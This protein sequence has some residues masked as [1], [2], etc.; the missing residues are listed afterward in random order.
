MMF[1]YSSIWLCIISFAYAS[2]Q[3]VTVQLQSGTVVTG[4]SSLGVD[5]F[6]GIP[7]ADPPVGQRRLRPP[8][9]LSRKLSSVDAR[10]IAAAC[11]QQLLSP[12]DR[13]ALGK[14][15]SQVLNLPILQELKGQEDCLSVSVQR[16]S[17]TKP[18]DK[19]P[20]VVWIYGGGF[21]LGSTNTYDATSLLRDAV[22]QHQPFVFVAINYR[23][24][25]F[26]FMPGADIKQEGSANAGLLDQRMGL[27]WV[28]DNVAQFGGDPDKVT[29]WGESAGSM[30]V[31]FQMAVFGGNATYNGKPL[32]RGGIMNSGTTSPADVIDGVKGQA[33][34]DQVVKEAGCSGI[35]KNETL[36]CLRNLDY[37]AF[38]KAVTETFPGIFSFFGN[39]NTFLPRADGHVLP[40]S[41][42]ELAATGQYH[43]VPLIVGDQEDEGTIFSIFQTSIK[44][45]DDFVNYL[46]ENMFANATKDQLS[47]L[48]E[49]YTKANE[50][51][52]FRSSPINSLYPM[53]RTIAAVLGDVTFTLSRRIF[54]ETATKIYPNVPIWSY[55]SSYAH[56]LPIL[57]TFHGSDLLQVFNGLP[58]SHATSST[59]QYY[60]NFFYNQDPNKGN[61]VDANWPL[62][63]ENKTL[64]W[65][66][67]LF[68]ND[69]LTDSFRGDQFAVLAKL[70][71]AKVLRQ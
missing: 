5:S 1:P 56:P 32:F 6:N 40:L 58:P 24:G 65:F 2:A 21:T 71:E 55:L 48:V 51:S 18:G 37:D 53:F 31:F 38:Y 29:L 27:E 35:E 45:D 57:G 44:T 43:A 49:V 4:R 15:G 19:L 60:F 61:V 70:A 11:P 54:I 23:L 46:S 28:A 52:P 25:A 36:S 68:S 7:Y 59:R 33:A 12:A 42:D 64:L 10:G 62:W 3:D 34:Y 26:G 14:L 67:T 8:Q 66:K 41:P 50:G 30:S 63:K 16:P 9:K 39:K 13:T 69:Y 22:A 20:V 17:S 47:E